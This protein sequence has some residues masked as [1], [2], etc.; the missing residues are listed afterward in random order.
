MSPKEGCQ[1]QLTSGDILELINTKHTHTLSLVNVCMQ[2]E[3][4]KQLTMVL[5]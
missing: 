5:T 4:W 2:C 3:V 1:V